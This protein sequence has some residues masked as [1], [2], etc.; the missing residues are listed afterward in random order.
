MSPE[1]DLHYAQDALSTVVVD[2][3]HWP[4]VFATWFDEPTES[5]VRSYFEVHATLLERARS[6]KEPFVLVT[7][8]FATKQ[9]AAKARKLIADL[10]N[11]QP[12]YAASMTIGSVIIIENAILRGVVT[13][14]R[15]ILPRMAES[16]TVGSV[17]GAIDYANATLGKHGI[18]RPAS[19]ATYKRPTKY[20]VDGPRSGARTS[21]V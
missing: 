3:R 14:L 1:P 16:E 4:V 11:A 6:N 2:A 13:A 18:Q 17:A 9:P 7:D 5:L 8:T 21:I 19:L 20:P 10:T 12:A 15:W